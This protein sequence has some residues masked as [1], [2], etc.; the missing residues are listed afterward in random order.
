MKDPEAA[1]KSGAFLQEHQDPADAETAGTA[2][3]LA[4]FES[5][6]VK[7][8]EALQ[9]EREQEKKEL[10]EFIVEK[11]ALM[12]AMTLFNSKLDDANEDKNKLSEEKAQATSENKQATDSKA[13]DSKALA[14]L[15]STC[16]DAAAAWDARQKHAANEQAAIQKAMEILGSR[17]KV[18]VQVNTETE[19]ASTQQSGPQAVRQQL[20][21]KFRSLGSKLHSLSMLNMVSAMSVSPMEKIKG[22]I[23]YMIAKLQKEAAEAASTHAFCQEENKKNA[24][25]KEKTQGELDKTNSRLESATA[26]KQSLEDRIAQLQNEVKDIEGADAKATQIR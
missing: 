1:P 19:K 8:Q 13:A 24:E 10:N 22:L 5:L 20:I 21:K 9:R 26:K 7:A 12:G 17:V 3:N 2:D 6:K 23:T 25:A 14:E 11:Q 16:N 15:T 4:T 18:L